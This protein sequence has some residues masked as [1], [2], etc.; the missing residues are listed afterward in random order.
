MRDFSLRQ[1]NFRRTI[2]HRN[3]KPPGKIFSRAD[4][5]GCVSCGLG[6]DRS[7][8][9]DPG[10]RRDT[11]CSRDSIARRSCRRSGSRHGGGSRA[12]HRLHRRNNFH[13]FP[14]FA[15]WNRYSAASAA[16]TH[17]A[18][19]SSGCRARCKPFGIDT[20]FG[21]AELGPP[22]SGGAGSPDRWSV[23]IFRKRRA[24]GCSSGCLA[25]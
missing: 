12:G 13:G 7:R 23:D 10:P 15:A 16:R 3:K 22:R 4:S 14:E 11:G 24:G 21:F 18:Q 5:P 19:D 20:S 6:F 9:P 8:M 17:S 25:V 1:K 2:W